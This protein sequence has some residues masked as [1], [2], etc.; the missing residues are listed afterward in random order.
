MQITGSSTIT[1]FGTSVP[2]LV[3]ECRFAGALTINNSSAIVLPGGANITTVA[4]DVLR[5]RS[6]G[7]GNWI[8]TGGTKGG[9]LPL[10]GGTVSGNTT[11]NAA[12]IA[13]NGFVANIASL[14]GTPGTGLIAQAGD[15]GLGTKGAAWINFTRPGITGINLGL[16]SDNVLRVGGGLFGSNSYRVV[17]E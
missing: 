4:G 8:Y 1:S 9:F 6:L 3:R 16:D 11:F 17:H 14:P 15:N 10:T 2:G 7:S 12:L 13:A 5:F